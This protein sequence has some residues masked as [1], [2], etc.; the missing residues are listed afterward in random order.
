MLWTEV[1]VNPGERELANPHEDNEG[2]GFYLGKKMDYISY[3][4]PDVTQ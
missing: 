2:Q 1:F 4:I 3:L